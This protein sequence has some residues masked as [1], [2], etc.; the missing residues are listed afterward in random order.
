MQG[1]FLQGRRPLILRRRRPDDTLVA[2]LIRLGA[3]PLEIPVM[4]MAPADAASAEI[5][6]SVLR[7]PNRFAAA[8]FTSPFAAQ[9]ALEAFAAHGQSMPAH[10][11]CLAVGQA[12]AEVLR[13]EGREVL[14]PEQDMT[15]EGV[16]ALDGLS[17]LEHHELVIFRGEGGRRAM[18]TGFAARDIRVTSCPLYRREADPSH[19]T[20]L[21]RAIEQRDFDAVILHSGELLDHLLA[22]IPASAVAALGDI[23]W[24]VP[25]ERLA[26]RLHA[27]GMARVEIADN[28]SPAAIVSALC[29]CYS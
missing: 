27:A 10:W 15:S 5:L 1:H 28:A 8:V 29:R 3:H 9:R 13:A 4:R 6:A 22:L 21:L 17:A 23:P 24:V 16:L 26:D 18:D 14:A 2:A 11:Q 25:V 12:T 19:R 20:E 7:D